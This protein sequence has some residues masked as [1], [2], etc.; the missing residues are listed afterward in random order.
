MADDKKA[1]GDK[2]KGEKKGGGSKPSALVFE[3]IVVLIII[4]LLGNFFGWFNMSGGGSSTNMGFIAQIQQY[5]IVHN[6]FDFLGTTAVIFTT[7]S[8]VLSVIMAVAIVLLV[9]KIR[10]LVKQWKI[11]YY[12][13]LSLHELPKE[14]KNSRWNKVVEHIS[15]ESPGDWRLAILECDIVL[16][17]LLDSLGFMGGTVSEKLKNLDTA[18]FK[19]VNNAWEA[20]KIRNAIAHEGQDFT[21]T[22]REA[23]RIVSLYEN[24]FKDFDFI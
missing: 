2:D 24:I 17:E 19:D 8:T 5:Q 18:H 7:V 23:K 4:Y 9:F 21:L 14:V 22:E 16:D 13:D 6:L 1:K 20:H 12:P 11:Q 15:S 10:E 3:V